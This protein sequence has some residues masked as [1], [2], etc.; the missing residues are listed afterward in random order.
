MAFHTSYQHW[1]RLPSPPLGHSST[2]TTTTTT[3]LYSHTHT[4]VYVRKS[5]WEWV[6][7]WSL[8]DHF[9]FLF[10]VGMVVLSLTGRGGVFGIC[11]WN[12]FTLV[13][14][15]GISLMQ[16]ER[17]FLPECGAPQYWVLAGYSFTWA[18]MLLPATQV[19]Y[20][21]HTWWCYSLLFLFL[22]YFFRNNTER[23]K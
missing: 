2:T 1:I 17:A 23:L 13:G 5:E 22:I 14:H 12:P 8:W 18:R 6:N 20:N 11:D 3:L 10:P 21:T 15:P 4:F 9:S 7:E 19:D 16:R